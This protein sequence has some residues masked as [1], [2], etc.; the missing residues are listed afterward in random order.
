MA[1]PE[2]IKLKEEPQADL[3]RY[4]ALLGTLV[5]AAAMMAPGSVTKVSRGTA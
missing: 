4:D 1:T 2:T 5:L 3:H